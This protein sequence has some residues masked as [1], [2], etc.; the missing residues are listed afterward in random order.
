[1][2]ETTEIPM[3]IV[4]VEFQ[5][6]RLTLA[7]ARTA[8]KEV[9]LFATKEEEKRHAEELARMNA[10]DFVKEAERAAKQDAQA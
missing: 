9:I 8:L 10:D 7:E 5:K 2:R 3:C 1:M 4:C 6:Q